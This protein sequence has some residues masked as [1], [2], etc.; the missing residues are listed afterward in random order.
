MNDVAMMMFDVGVFCVCVSYG[1]LTYFRDLL[2][3]THKRIVTITKVYIAANNIHVEIIRF[4]KNYG[5]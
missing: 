5:I 2:R 4:R 3:C 1:S